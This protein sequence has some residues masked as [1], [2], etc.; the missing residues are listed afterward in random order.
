VY[1]AAE[2]R[3]EEDSGARIARPAEFPI[4]AA[5]RVI[6]LVFEIALA[7]A[8]GLVTGMGLQVVATTGVLAPGWE[9]R[10][11]SLDATGFALGLIGSTLYHTLS[12]WLGGASVGKWL[13][14]LRVHTAE[15]SLDRTFLRGL[16]PCTARGALIRTLALYVDAMFC[17]AV[18]YFT[19]IN[20]GTQARL[21]DRWGRTIVVVAKE[22]RGA[23]PRSPALGLLAGVGA[24]AICLVVSMILRVL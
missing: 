2:P 4:R 7:M 13:C 15:L 10:L 17:G 9:A 3:D 23:Q 16:H 1:R 20:S 14:G 12:E 11:G 22:T 24:S 5:A 6:D 19:M 8:V 21:G 18:A